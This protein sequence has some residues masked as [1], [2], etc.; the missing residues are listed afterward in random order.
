MSAS[1]LISSKNS[2]A[3]NK[4]KNKLA[5]LVSE[6]PK[7]NDSLALLVSEAPK[8]DYALWKL[9]VEAP[10][11]PEYTNSWLEKTNKIIKSLE[12]KIG[13][14][15]QHHFEEAYCAAQHLLHVLLCARDAYQL[16]RGSLNQSHECAMEDFN[17]ACTQIIAKVRP[18]LERD[19]GWGDY[20]TNLLKTIVN[21]TISIV[22]LGQVGTFFTPKQSQSL[23]HTEKAI[24]ELLNEVQQE[25]ETPTA[26]QP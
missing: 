6:A 16:H 13:G 8:K 3:S 20:L 1:K 26:N 22:T 23:A 5:L 7:K 21:T 25:P 2:N 4:A 10:K 15:D 19:L 17:Y 11:K 9:A 18:V 24:K 14:I 12:Q